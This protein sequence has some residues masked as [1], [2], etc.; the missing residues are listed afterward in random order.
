MDK[1]LKD[2][3][4][5]MIEYDS[6][7]PKRIQHFLKV[8]E[9]ASLI[10]QM[11]NLDE[12]TQFILEAAS[13]VHDIGIKNA[14]AKYNSHAGY[15]QEQE[16]PE[17]ARILLEKVGGYSEEEIERILFLVGHH[18][19][20]KNVDGIDWRILI[21]ADFLVNLYE[22]E[23]RYKAILAAENNVFETASGKWIL[24]QQFGIE[25]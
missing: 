12:K 19:T 11:E 5:A 8:Y 2:T 23:S 3:A 21:E 15:L 17:E 13:L 10:G 24:H 9:F 6:G 16:G 14:M 22:S 20:Y 25:Y 7:T 4:I 1:R 18:H